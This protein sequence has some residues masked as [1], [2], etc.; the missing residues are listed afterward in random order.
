MAEKEHK[1]S[2]EE[3]IEDLTAEEREV[4]DALVAYIEAEGQWEEVPD[5]VEETMTAEALEAFIM[6]EKTFADVL[7][8]TMDEAYSVGELA[9]TLMEQGNLADAQALAEGL[10]VMNPYDAY[11]HALLGSI[12]LKQ[13]KTEDALIEFTTALELDERDVASYTNRGEVLLQMGEFDLAL[14]D[15]KKAIELDP[16]GDDP[17]SN[18]ARMLVTV[19]TMVIRKAVEKSTA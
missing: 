7:G 15:F 1:V 2:A 19:A 12:Y 13:A 18:R 10:V 14:E 5:P 4:A 9:Y 6:G 8:V 3:P 11:F 17:M 16:E